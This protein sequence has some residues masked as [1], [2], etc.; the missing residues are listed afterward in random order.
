M[1]PS[2]VC[3]DFDSPGC[4]AGASYRFH[5]G[6]ADVTQIVGL[7]ADIFDTHDVVVE[8]ADV[9]EAHTQ[10]YAPLPVAQ[11]SGADDGYGDAADAG[12]GQGGGKADIRVVEVEIAAVSE[13]CQ[14][15]F[16]FA[17]PVGIESVEVFC[18]GQGRSS[19][20]VFQS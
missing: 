14:M 9:P 18:C 15:V 10:Q 6:Q 17:D 12:Q 4:Y 16:K 2:I 7:W 19:G 11:P 8:D 5:L 3:C 13:V 20:L 1:Y